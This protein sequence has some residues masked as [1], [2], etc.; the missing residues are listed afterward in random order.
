MEIL[1]GFLG[2]NFSEEKMSSVLG[3]LREALGF[4]LPAAAKQAALA[5]RPR[6]VPFTYHDV[7]AEYEITPENANMI[8]SEIQRYTFVCV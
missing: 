4:E 8:V 3:G 7:S 5:K 2:Q 6:S 1:W